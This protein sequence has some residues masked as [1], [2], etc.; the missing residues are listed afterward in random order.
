MPIRITVQPFK[1]GSWLVAIVLTCGLGARVRADEPAPAAPAAPTDNSGDVELASRFAQMAQ[2]TLRN[3]TPTDL[4]WKQAA[5]LLK[6]A[7]RLST[8]DPRYPLMEAEARLHYRDVDGAIE[9]YHAYMAIPGYGDDRVVQLAYIQ[10]QA[11][12]L[13]TADAKLAYLDPMIRREDSG[14]APEVRS[15][16]AVLAAQVLR[17]KSDTVQALAMIDLAL[18]L[19]P[20]NLAA[21]EEH[22]N[23]V[24]VNGSIADRVH[25]LLAMM[26]SNPTQIST[27]ASLGR[28]L[29][30]AG[31]PADALNWY[32]LGSNY[33]QVLGMQLPHEYCAELAGE[34][35]VIGQST[36]ASQLA[37]E[38]L[39]SNSSDYEM[40]LFR[41]LAEREA[42]NKD[43]IDKSLA[44]AQ[45]IL[46][47]SLETIRRQ[48]GDTA[49][50]TR[51]VPG[52]PV[53]EWGD[54]TPDLNK[55][56][57]PENEKF[58]EQYVNTLKELAW[59]ELY[60]DKK[61]AEASGFLAA[62]GQL[63]PADDALLARLQGWSYLDSNQK[64]Q[65]K[66]KLSAVA[67]D[68]AY[69]QLGLI[70]LGGSSDEEKKQST[71]A[72]TKLLGDHPAGLLGATL[73]EALHDRV[74]T[75]PVHP[76]AARIRAELDKF[77]KEWLD[78]VRKPGEFYKLDASPV[79]IAHAYAEP[80]YGKVT[81]ENI[82]NFD[83]TVG[84]DGTS[85]PSLWFDAQT[86]G[87]KPESYIGVCVEEL[88]QRLI[89]H[90]GESIT[91][92]VRLDQGVL[93]QLLA[94]SPQ[95]PFVM[96]F[97][98]HTNPT[99]TTRSMTLLGGYAALFN[100]PVERVGFPLDT[101]HI[102]KLLAEIQTGVQAK[103][104]RG[105]DMALA[106]LSI[107][108]NQVNKQ[109]AN[110]KMIHDLVT[111]LQQVVS[112]RMS[113]P[114]A[115]ASVR[116]WTQYCVARHMLE[117]DRALICEKMMAEP[118]WQSRMLA[119]AAMAGLP[120]EK[121][122]ALIGT[123]AQRDTDMLVRELGG[124]ES[125]LIQVAAAIAATQAA[126]LPTTG[127]NTAGS[128]LPATM[129]SDL[130]LPPMLT[131]STAP[132]VIPDTA[133]PAPPAAAPAAA[134]A[135]APSAV[136]PAIAPSTAPATMP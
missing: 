96:Q 5:V 25:T 95:P 70:E 55:L 51:P 12:K 121:Q 131:P 1:I 100:K 97:Q 48:L 126:T 23:Q 113:D 15:R 83:I 35:L 87:L 92:I 125:E 132:S 49:A 29:S 22:Y 60:F 11:G 38:L 47:N 94:N 72:A 78:I 61:P 26:R 63:L 79:G 58:K 102:N 24:D 116:A 8:D 45:L 37:D 120:L 41:L 135:S 28:E 130:L 54:L 127:P 68:D 14:L 76:D 112:G 115:S 91:Q 53:L 109:D 74:A 90:K 101:P 50:T 21:L 114:N 17:E 108:Q 123:A 67:G 110:G 36:L 39:K 3:G 119:L 31:M 69:A 104:I 43:A 99:T 44:Q 81:I 59:L 75:P 40:L 57:E 118:Q 9:A 46:Y 42:K 34:F 117:K 71:A 56:K 27:V 52:P 107:L 13:E 19:D 136:P 106:L 30:S 103:Q 86:H 65:A 4:Q 7:H 64:E 93:G 20:L 82:S 6:A 62:L 133:P 16:A 18:K 134:P 32:V 124:V 129:P 73:Y 10:L 122:S 111:T 66:V 128:T 33:A 85:L 77:P 89:L 98:V 2:D 88:G 84:P 105:V 80:I